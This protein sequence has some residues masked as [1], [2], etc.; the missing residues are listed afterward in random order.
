R[1]RHHQAFTV[2]ACIASLFMLAAIPFHFAGTSWALVWLLQ[3]EMLFV[4]GFA[5]RETL[6]RHL[7]IVS[8]LA[9]VAQLIG[10]VALPV[11]TQRLLGPDTSHHTNAA[12]AFACGALAA[13]FN[14]EF[15]TRRW[16]HLL[17]DDFDRMMLRVTSY[18]AALCAGVAV[19]LAVPGVWMLLPWLAA[20]AV[21]ALI[22]TRLRSTNLAQQADLFCLA[23]ITRAALVNFAQWD[24]FAN[25]PRTV[26]LLLASALLYANMRR[27]QPAHI[28]PQALIE[29]AYAWAAA[30]LLSVL[31]WYAL[32]P[33]AVAVAW[34]LM[35]TVYLETG[36]AS[37]R[38]FFRHQGF[39]LLVASFV[40]LFF[41]NIALA[42]S[43]RMYTMLPLAA[44]YAW[45][46][47]RLHASEPREGFDRFA[48]AINAWFATSTVTT[49]LYFSL[50]PEWVAAGGAALAV[51]ILLLARVLKRPLFTAQAMLLVLLAAGRTLAFN[52]LSPDPLAANFTAG[53]IFT[54][55]LPCALLFAALPIAFSLRRLGQE[56][57]QEERA[58]LHPLL[59]H[60][61]QVL[62]F[63]PLLVL[64]AWVPVQLR[65][66]MITVGWS[67]LGVLTFLFALTVSERSY[68]LAGLGT[69]LV[70]VGKII[71]VDIWQAAPIDR[72]ITLIVMGAALL[73]VSFLYSRYRETILEL[74]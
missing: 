25:A 58:A 16:P 59:R 62:F 33:A 1:R 50:R 6:F 28:L 14:A 5:S 72:Y 2:L 9:A 45:V 31:A 21:L 41:I 60:P 22:S 53:R 12:L 42:P 56:G 74:L 68:R 23:A 19:W 37:R 7:G 49:L 40:R 61:E 43:P 51:A 63:A 70:G 55:G 35:G 20:A 73:F 52:V 4:A 57:T 29:P 46:Y 54:A 13:W 27:R 64:F 32:Q 3:A 10:A 44:L 67:V 24:Q 8:G 34:C 66:D 15:A 36:I 30:G 48:G 65:A 69:L 39:V 17:A 26:I 11:F 71:T 47:Q 18:V 38:N